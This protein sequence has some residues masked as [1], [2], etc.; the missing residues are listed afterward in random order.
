MG[1]EEGKMTF[2]TDQLM[3][4]LALE[5]LRNKNMLEF[6]A[7]G[8]SMSPFIRNKDMVIVSPCNPNKMRF[9]DIILYSTSP[10][11]NQSQKRIH[12]IMKR[13][14]VNGK[15]LF[16]AKGDASRCLDPPIEPNQVLGKISAI[17][18]ERWTLNLNQPWGKAI[19]LTWALFQRW[20]LSMWMLRMG[21]KVMK[22]VICLC[23]LSG[24][25]LWFWGEAKP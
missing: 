2:C 6:T 17:K 11:P 5:L 24:L 18:K 25:F 14:T 12:R 23:G 21:W 16:F 15:S 7:T 10:N 1:T 19:N 3:W 13:R 9:G 22:A 8:T 4:D 20:P